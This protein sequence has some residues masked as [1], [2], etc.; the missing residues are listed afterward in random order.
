MLKEQTEERDRMKE[1]Q[2]RAAG[3]SGERDEGKR[4]DSNFRKNGGEL[5]LTRHWTSKS[6]EWVLVPPESASATTLE[7]VWL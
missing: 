5:R 2:G 6:R 7:D 1:E 3:R 4:V